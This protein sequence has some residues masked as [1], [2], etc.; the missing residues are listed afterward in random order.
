M[1]EALYM[2]SD[3]LRFPLSNKFQ[4]LHFIGFQGYWKC[5]GPPETI[6]IEPGASILLLKFKQE[7]TKSTFALLSKSEPCMWNTS[8]NVPGKQRDRFP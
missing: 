6:I 2:Y 3:R 8:K 4:T 1:P 5:Q 7:N